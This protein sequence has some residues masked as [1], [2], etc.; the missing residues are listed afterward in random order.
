MAELPDVP[1]LRVLEPPPGG[2]AV[3]RERLDERRPRWWLLAVPA[4]VVAAVVLIL[5]RTRE[6]APQP[7]VS[8]V[9]PDRSVGERFYWVASTPGSPA[10]PA[11]RIEAVSTI[12]IAEAPQV[13]ALP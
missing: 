6:V 7:P 8:T 5:L 3:L 9:L 11:P 10:A 13:E 1:A 12:S 4:L 2:L